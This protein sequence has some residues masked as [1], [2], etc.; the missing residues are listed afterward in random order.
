MKRLRFDELVL[1]STQARRA[2]TTR[3]HP[4]TTIIQGDNDVGKSCLLKSIFWCLGAKPRMHSSW[5]KTAPLALLSLTVD[6]ERYYLLRQASHFAVFDS[7]ERLIRTFASVTRDLSPYLARLLDFRL[8]LSQKENDSAI[9]PTPA[10]KFLPYYMDQDRSWKDNWSSFEQLQQF[11]RFRRDLVEYHVGMRPNEYF[12][13]MERKADVDR[14]I[15]HSEQ[16]TQSIR[17]VL[18]SF[19]RRT[20]TE[21]VVTD[22]DEFRKEITEL[23]VEVESLTKKAADIKDELTR[24]HNRRI[25]IDAQI[26]IAK[27]ALKEVSADFDYTTY[28]IADDMVECPTCGAEYENRFA[29][30]F[31]IAKDED[32]C[33]ELIAELEG[34]RQVVDAEMAETE[35]RYT[36]MQSN[37]EKLHHILA[38]KRGNVRLQDVIATEGRR[39]VR[40]TLKADI[41]TRRSR[42]AALLEDKTAIDVAMKASQDREK[43]LEIQQFYLARMRQFVHILDAGSLDEKSYKRIDSKINE[44]GSALPRSLLAYFMSILHTIDQYGSSAMCP[45]VID[46]PDQQGQDDLNMA[47][48]LKFIRDYR[49]PD[50][51]LILGIVDDRGVKFEGET[52]RLVDKRRL[53]QTQQYDAAL[54]RVKP[55]LDQ[56]LSISS[57]E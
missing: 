21:E 53:L 31:S 54:A 55:F 12:D 20:E 47:T 48:A 4:Q 36:D 41:V 5:V 16:E 13:L 24:L 17:Q 11:S 6:D 29:E 45:V 35:T 19:E 57:Q 7:S 42:E 43:R 38:T 27:S 34:E 26:A 33:Y 15:R 18:D 2:R 3:F 22:L 49:P 52:V 28:I 8:R 40:K 23:L 37:Q 10:F 25:I 30:R 44:T 51:Q 39:G 9:I 46:E 32:R 1:V 50:S 56:S 14:E